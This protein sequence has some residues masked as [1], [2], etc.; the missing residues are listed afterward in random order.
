MLS[1]AGLDTSKRIPRE[2][3][4]YARAR[5][6]GAPPAKGVNDEH[7]F[8]ITHGPRYLLACDLGVLTVSQVMP[9]D[10]V[11]GSVLYFLGSP[12]R[13]GPEA[14]AGRQGRGGP[15][16]RGCMPSVWGA[17]CLGVSAA[18]EGRCPASVTQRQTAAPRARY[19]I[20]DTVGQVLP[21]T[22]SD[23]RYAGCP[24]L[25]GEP[26]AVQHAGACAVTLRRSP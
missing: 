17:G 6:V 21:R 24:C 1:H 26:P 2:K 19:R 4:R 25:R 15:D 13:C 11:S 22:R 18:E 14:R 12:G 20:G 10:G 23:D 16:Y 3:R 5:P 9:S 7:Q 8:W